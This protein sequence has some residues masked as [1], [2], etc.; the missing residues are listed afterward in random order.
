MVAKE[1][2]EA[3]EP[4]AAWRRRYER[5]EAEHPHIRDAHADWQERMEALWSELWTTEEVGS[6]L[7]LRRSR[8]PDGL[9]E[10]L[11]RRRAY[12][13][14]EARELPQ[15]P[16]EWH[17]RRRQLLAELG[18]PGAE[19]WDALP[20]GPVASMHEEAWEHMGTW[21][22]ES[23]ETDAAPLGFD[24]CRWVLVH[25]FRHRCH[26]ETEGRRYVEITGLPDGPTITRDSP[27]PAPDD[28]EMLLARGMLEEGVDAD[29]AGVPLLDATAASVL[30]HALG[31]DELGGD[32][33]P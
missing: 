17:R 26:P 30:A 2:V 11:V 4:D 8:H 33:P 19:V 22:Q 31:S 7:G 12:L 23:A 10:D 32:R 15:W 16:D 13:V 28:L 14:A 6:G 25:R 1:W 5:L 20:G 9:P 27:S 24:L 21:R 18:Y 29:V 3:R